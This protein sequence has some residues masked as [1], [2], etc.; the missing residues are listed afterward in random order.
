MWLTNSFVCRNASAGI[1]AL[2]V[3][4]LNKLSN[5]TEIEGY[6]AVTNTADLSFTNLAFLSNLRAIRGRFTPY[7]AR[8]SI[9][10]VGNLHLRALRTTSLE[11]VDR[12][13]IKITNNRELSYVDTVNWTEI[14]RAP[15][16][17]GPSGVE[18]T[19]N[20]NRT[21]SG[22]TCLCRSQMMFSQSVLLIVQLGDVC[23]VEC[24]GCWF[25]GPTN[26]AKCENHE[27]QGVCVAECN[28]QL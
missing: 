18:V 20:Q 19:D 24:N 5:I 7:G 28:L 16:T 26:C 1:Q 12:G 22:M 21:V 4:D 14:V 27:F 11:R 6:L 23:D 15:L 2:T 9:Y 3:T 25:T 13:D 8:Y 10:I 17:F